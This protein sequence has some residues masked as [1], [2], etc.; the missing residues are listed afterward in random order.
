MLGPARMVVKL[1]AG[2]RIITPAKR[3][4]AVRISGFGSNA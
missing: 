4:R 2:P 1:S 3:V